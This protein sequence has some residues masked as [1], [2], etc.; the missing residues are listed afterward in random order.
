MGEEDSHKY[1]ITIAYDGTRYGGWQIQPNSLSIQEQIESILQVFLQREVKLVGAGRTDAGVHALGQTAHFTF[2]RP[3]DAYR[4]LRAAN[5]L[6]PTDIRIKS[7]QS[8]PPDFH[9]RYSAKR[10]IYHYHLYLDPIEDPFKVNTVYKPIYRIDLE[11]LKRCMELYLGTH[12]FS[13]FANSQTE[14]VAAHDPVRTMIRADVV[15]EEGGVRLEFEAD[16][17]LYKMVRNL[18][19]TALAA[20]SKKIKLEEIPGIFH[21]RDR[22]KAGQSVPPQGLFLV[23]V[24]YD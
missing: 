22:R 15:P 20:A 19:G 13:A 14:G 21:G 10:K 16:G 2:D 3:V 18:V 24:T 11:L 17:F 9:A 7:I 1:L 5:G 12:D 4:F 8:V 23:K 6:L